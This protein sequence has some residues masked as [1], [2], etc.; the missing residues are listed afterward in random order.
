MKRFQKTLCYVICSVFL[1]TSPMTAYAAPEIQAPSYILMEASTGQVICEQNAKERRSPAS[2]TKIMTLLIAISKSDPDEIV[3][4][5]ASAGQVPL[6][7]SVVPVY[8]GEKMPM[9]DLWYG[10]IFKS[11]NDAANAIAELVS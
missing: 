2:I 9:R 5:P 4:V 6:D 8:P 3:T 11:G 1:L 10:L 7:S